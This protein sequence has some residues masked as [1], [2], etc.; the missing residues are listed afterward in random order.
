MTFVVIP[1]QN[2]F[3]SKKG[4]MRLTADPLMEPKRMD[5]ARWNEDFAF[6]KLYLGSD[7]SAQRITTIHASKRRLGLRFNLRWL[8]DRGCGK[9]TLVITWEMNAHDLMRIKAEDDICGG[10]KGRV[11]WM[12]DEWIWTSFSLNF[13]SSFF[14]Y[15][16]HCQK[17]ETELFWEH[18]IFPYSIIN[19]V[20]FG[21]W[22]KVVTE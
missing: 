16:S 6:E 5:D 22:G 7:D 19:L 17:Q 10:T 18:N 20:C 12:N 4:A 9:A 3:T 15:S 14:N 8:I 2:V 13:N 21:W 11:L 1:L